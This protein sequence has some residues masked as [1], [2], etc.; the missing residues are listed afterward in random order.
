[1][2]DTVT[3][4]A[5]TAIG[6]NPDGNISVGKLDD[7]IKRLTAEAGPLK[8]VLEAGGSAGVA[9]QQSKLSREADDHQRVFKRNRDVVIWVI[10]LALVLSIAAL[11]VPLPETYGQ[12]T[13]GFRLGTVLIVYFAL[14]VP[15]VIGLMELRSD[16]RQKWNEARGDAEHLRRR[17]FDVVMDGKADVNSG[18]IALLPLKLEYFRRYQLEVQREYH[19]VKSK[20]NAGQAALAKWL[21]IPCML[22]VIG[23]VILMGLVYTAAAGEQGPPPT[24]LPDAVLGAAAELHVIER[25]GLDIIGLLLGIALAALYGAAYL[26]SLLFTH[27]RNASRF[28]RALENM[29]YLMGAP[30]AEARVAAVK[31][32]EVA[33]RAFVAQVHSVMSTEYADWIRLRKIDEGLRDTGPA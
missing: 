31:G 32:D 4:A 3:A 13:A 29:E 27:Q 16:P 11:V 26:R 15:L 17:R 5:V 7:H 30:L 8:R 14:L 10:L 24:W 22:V 6:A 12:L 2:S 1:M 20:E 33:V 28:E 21:I 9:G 18:E 23:W 19:K 25:F